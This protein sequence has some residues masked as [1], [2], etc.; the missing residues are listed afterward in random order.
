[1]KKKTLL[2]SLV[3][4]ALCLCIIVGS[5]FA[6]FTSE[7]TVNMAAT[8]GTVDVVASVD[9]NSLVT[10]S[11]DVVQQYGYFQLGGTAKYDAVNGLTL[12]NMAPGDAVEFN[13]QVKNNSNVAIKYRV[14]WAISGELADAD[15]LSCTAADLPIV[16]NVTAWTDWSVPASDAERLRDVKV[17]ISLPASVSNVYQDKSA[18]VIFVVEAVQGNGLI[19]NVASYAAF[20]DILDDSEAGDMLQLTLVGDIVADPQDTLYIP[21]GV[22][23]TLDVNGFVFDVA[24]ENEGSFAISGVPADSLDI[25]GSGSVSYH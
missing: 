7:A 23:V 1:M 12:S 18:T 16:D 14:K 10:T 17:K 8:S 20:A 13:I 3:A 9:E 15:V 22:T 6:L 11:F 5:T 2:T 21:S 25:S 4:T 24:V 19:E